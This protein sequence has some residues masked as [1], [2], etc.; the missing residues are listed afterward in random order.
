VIAQK[1]NIMFRK[2]EFPSESAMLR[3]KLYV[4]PKSSSPS[5]VAIMAH[6]F[7]ATID[8][9]VAE[10]YAEVFYD[11][12]FAVLLND[13][14]NFGMSGGEP[15]QEINKW[16]QA[17]GYRDAMNFVVT[18]TDIDKGRIAIWGDSIS[19]A[20][21]I[22][23][24]AVDER[25]RTIIVQVPACGA[26]PPPD[27]SEGLIFES[28]KETFQHGNVNGTPDTTIGPLPVVSFDQMSTPS[29]LTP[30]TSFRWFIEYGARYGTNWKNRATIVNPK[31][32]VL[33]NSTLCAPYLKAPMQMVVA[34][35][36]EMP[37]ANSNIARMTFERAPQPKELIEMDGGHFGLLYYPS[38][39]FDQVSVAQRDFLI[40]HLA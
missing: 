8:G 18:L 9:M 33:Y 30:L 5:P 16:V 31:T 21:A 7:S 2:V 38:E 36:D 29:L 15:R 11:A 14:R 3:G 23:V 19:G 24:G 10:K 35:E 1:E 25:V 12:G 22:L 28:I 13:H 26:G 40:R 6:G 32:P 20:E 27:D 34:I 37:G 4:H 17:R 39:L